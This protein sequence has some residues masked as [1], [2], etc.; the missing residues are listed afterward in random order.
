MR[1]LACGMAV[2]LFAGAPASAAVIGGAVT[3]GNSGGSFTLIAPPAQ[4]G[5]NNQVSN[6]LIAWNERQGVTLGAVL[7]TD[8]GGP[9]SAGTQVSSHGVVFDPAQSR[10][11]I[12][13]I[14]FASPVLGLIFTRNR[15]IASDFLG[16]PGTT[17]NSP[18]ARGLES[19]DSASIDGMLPN[20]VLIDWTASSPGDNIR[21]ITAVPEPATWATMIGG[22]GLI[23]G[24]L[25]RRGATIAAA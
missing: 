21:V 19:G 22:F 23:G 6:N 14:D 10:S 3:G 25:R 17:Y 1:S 15:L 12:G 4:T 11:M 16:A 7:M 5:N 18:S 13:Y 9:I 2:V 8:V 24:A 20:R